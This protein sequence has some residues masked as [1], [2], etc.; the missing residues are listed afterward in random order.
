LIKP[1]ALGDVV[2]TLPVLGALRKRWPQAEITW[3]INRGLAGLLEGHPQVDAIVEFDRPRFRGWGMWRAGRELW[4][5][6]RGR[7]FDLT[8]DLQGLLRS[9]LMTLA[10]GAPTRVGL[11]TAREGSRWAYTHRVPVES[12]DMPALDRYWLLMRA[13]GVITPPPPAVLGI[14]NQHREWVNQQLSGLP[15]PLLACVPGAQWETKR[16]PAA[17]FATVLEEAH[18]EF[19]AGIVLLGG[20]GEEPLCDE[21]RKSLSKDVPVV[22]LSGR[23]NLLNLAATLATVDVLLSGDTGPMHLAAA[24]GT[25]CVSLFTCTSPLR[26]G[27][28]GACHRLV[29]TEVPCQG[30]YLKKCPKMVCMDDLSVERVWA[31]VSDALDSSLVIPLTRR[32]PAV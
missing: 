13:L 21:V 32:R 3:V 6:L 12:L 4:K 28:R 22:D 7:E 17:K 23:T 19:Q 15:R 31:G 11:S 25:P 26:A 8:I 5:D 9:G 14:T 1:S 30:S 16:W 27:P 2:Q 18:R 24:V 10:T 29:V 20:P